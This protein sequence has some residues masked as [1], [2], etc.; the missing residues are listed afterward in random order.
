MIP[1]GSVLVLDTNVLVH[2]V[3]NNEIGRGVLAD[4]EKA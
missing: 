3:R 1:T 2:L 4:R